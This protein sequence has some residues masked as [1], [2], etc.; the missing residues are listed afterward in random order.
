[1]VFMCFFLLLCTTIYNLKCQS[2]RKQFNPGTIFE[3]LSRILLASIWSLENKLNNLRDRVHFQR[4]IWD[5]KRLC[6]GGDCLRVKSR[7]CKS[8]SIVPLTPNLKLISTIKCNPF[9]PHNEFTSIIDRIV[10]YS[11]SGRHGHGLMWIAWGFQ[12]PGFY[13]LHWLAITIK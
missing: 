2:W 1:M 13:S 8:T 9:Y 10:L 6:I 12:S 3:A 4:N 11:T 5:C 7:R